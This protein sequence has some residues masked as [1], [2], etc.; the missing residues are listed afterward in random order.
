MVA[1]NLEGPGERSSE[2]ST[3]LYLNFSGTNVT[4]KLMEAR[5]SCIAH[6]AELSSVSDLL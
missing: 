4:S 3:S 5:D 2:T 6:Q 1:N